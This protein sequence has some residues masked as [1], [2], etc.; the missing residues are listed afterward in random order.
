[1]IRLVREHGSLHLGT[2]QSVGTKVLPDFLSVIFDP[3]RRK[4][5]N[6]DLNGWYV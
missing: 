2:L 4:V 3:T 6:A 5:G 1:M